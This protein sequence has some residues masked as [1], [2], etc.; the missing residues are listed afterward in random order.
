MSIKH[1][2]FGKPPPLPFPLVPGPTVAERL[3]SYEAR[4]VRAYI[5][6]HGEST[7]SECGLQSAALLAHAID[8]GLQRGWEWR[9]A[10][11][12]PKGNG[13]E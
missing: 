7:W 13:H 4:G 10:I 2:L 8:R 6:M 3:A 5:Q 12:E 11:V 9:L 1:L